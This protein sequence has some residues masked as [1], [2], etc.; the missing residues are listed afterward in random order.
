MIRK[1]I[2]VAVVL[3][4]LIGVWLFLGENRLL[5]P[6]KYGSE[7]ELWTATRSYSF[8]IGEEWVHNYVP[9]TSSCSWETTASNP[10]FLASTLF[11]QPLNINSDDQVTSLSHQ[12]ACVPH[13]FGYNISQG[14]SIF[15]LQNIIHCKDRYEPE[16]RPKIWY[17]AENEEFGIECPRGRIG[18]Y[19]IHPKEIVVTDELKLEKLQRYWRVETSSLKPYFSLDFSLK[20]T[21]E[22]RILSTNS[23]TAGLSSLLSSFFLQ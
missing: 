1:E 11:R 8:G 23:A 5:L 9:C 20:Y 3:L 7:T 2:A 16:P 4:S 17:N 10:A 13:P 21:P 14:S 19:V 18:R 22:P 15:P 12:L 6:Y